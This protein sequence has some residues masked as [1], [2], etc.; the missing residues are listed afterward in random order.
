MT[1]KPMPLMTEHNRGLIRAGLKT[2]TRRVIG[3]DM[4]T[5]P[6]TEAR[7]SSEGILQMRCPPENM[8][9]A[10]IFWGNN[11]GPKSRHCKPIKPRAQVGDIWWMREPCRVD[12]CFSAE[13]GNIV[14]KYTDNLE[15]FDVD[16]TEAKFKKWRNRKKP[17]AKTSSL[18]MYKSLSRT[19]RK[20]T[21]VWIEQTQSISWQD[22]R[23]EGVSCP[24]HDFAGGFCCSECKSLRQAWISLWNNINASRGYGYEKNTWNFCYGFEEIEMSIQKGSRVKVFDHLLYE[25]DV[26]TPLSATVK[27]A[28]V[29]KRYIYGDHKRDVID[30]IFDHRPDEISIAHF[31]NTAE[32]IEK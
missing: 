24:E 31:T 27:P 19:R 10:D 14:G 28:T 20:V 26:S 3:L 2:Q 8:I 32:E 18:F 4:E 7:I 5:L 6:N 17:Y 9:W 25:D 22:I 13:S 12:H 15:P 11:R 29:H 1:Q 23:A 16:L 21:R 30:V